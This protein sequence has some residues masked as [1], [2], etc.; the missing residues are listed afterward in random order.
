MACEIDRDFYCTNAEDFISSDGTEV[1]C[2]TDHYCE[3]CRNKRRKWPTPEQF[4]EEW[5]WEWAGAVYTRC[6]A[7][8]CRIPGC[9]YGYGWSNVPDIF[10]N[11]PDCQPFLVKVCA[12][13]PW[14]KP[15]D[16]W[17]PS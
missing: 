15:E 16:N 12:C 8:F 11:H 13:S 1:R 10:D 17:R 7:E 2:D 5:G 3:T 14:D 4:R 6:V 9:R